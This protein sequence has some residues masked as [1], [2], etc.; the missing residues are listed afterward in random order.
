MSNMIMKIHS[1]I[2]MQ[3]EVHIQTERHPKTLMIW[4]RCKA[5][6][7]WTSVGVCVYVEPYFFSPFESYF[8]RL[9]SQPDLFEHWVHYFPVVG[10]I[11][12][13]F[14][15]ASPF[16]SMHHGG[17]YPFDM[18]LW[19]GFTE[20]SQCWAHANDRAVE[21]LQLY[22]FI[23]HNVGDRTGWNIHDAS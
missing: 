8:D 1:W 9:W 17:Y 2:E 12:T 20:E 22:H 23:P 5:V 15:W 18:Q 4:F 11:P 10:K 21:L 16:S 7:L 3:L 19:C 6:V 14:F 13:L